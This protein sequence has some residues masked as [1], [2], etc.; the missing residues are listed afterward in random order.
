MWGL[1]TLSACATGVSVVAD[2]DEL[3]G[4]IRGLLRAGARSSLLTL[5]NVR[6]S[7]TADF[8]KSFYRHLRKSP[9]NRESALRTAMLEM[10]ERHANPYY[11]A[12]YVLIGRVSTP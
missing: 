8:M 6:D 11:W 10:R 12:P 2:G 1:V 9:A 7:T 3:L 5:W 4:L